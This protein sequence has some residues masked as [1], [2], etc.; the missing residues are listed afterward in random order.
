MS[1]FKVVDGK[2]KSYPKKRIG[3]KMV[4]LARYIYQEFYG[5]KLLPDIVVHHKN[6][7]AFDNRI[8]NLELLPFGEHTAMHNRSR[9]LKYGI[10]FSDDPKAYRRTWYY[11]NLEKSRKYARDYYRE[12]YS[13]GKKVAD[14]LY[15]K[16]TN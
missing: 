2:R 6:G 9:G 8:E 12:N 16:E 1:S 5:I 4:K 10:R 11:N 3:K 7:D 15:G 13:K 14:F